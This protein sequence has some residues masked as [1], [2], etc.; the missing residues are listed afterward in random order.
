MRTVVYATDVERN[1]PA[2]FIERVRGRV[3]SWTWEVPQELHAAF[4]AEYAAWC[5]DHYGDLER[6]FA[7]RVQ[8]ELQVWTVP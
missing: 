4:L 1:K 7:Q 6:E 3:D 5:R 8:Y 2:D